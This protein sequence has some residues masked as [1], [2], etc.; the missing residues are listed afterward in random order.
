MDTE[1]TDAFYD[2]THE[3]EAAKELD[4]AM[5]NIAR[6]LH[7][8][9]QLG[10]PQDLVLKLVERRSNFRWQADVAEVPTLSQL[11]GVPTADKIPGTSAKARA[12]QTMASKFKGKLNRINTDPKAKAIMWP[13]SLDADAPPDEPRSYFDLMFDA[14]LCVMKVMKTR[15][16][17]ATG[18]APA[19]APTDAAA[20]PTDAAVPAAVLRALSE[21]A[22]PGSLPPGLL[23][24]W[25]LPLLK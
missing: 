23:S 12:S 4:Q 18:N 24:L 13:S 7:A 2:D 22:R 15:R 17:Q 14:L 5:A 10:V 19:A 9:H 16:E 6:A 1:P 8:F 20:A 3:P 25:S 21:P 11:I